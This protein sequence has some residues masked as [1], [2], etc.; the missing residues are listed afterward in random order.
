MTHVRIDLLAPSDTVTHCPYKGQAENWSV[1]VHAEFAWSYRAPFPASQEIAGLIAFY[2]E[3]VDI[4]VDGVLQ[5]RPPT[6][7]SRHALALGQRPAA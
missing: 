2:N 6:K 4:Y 5:E 1:G 7:F 3:K